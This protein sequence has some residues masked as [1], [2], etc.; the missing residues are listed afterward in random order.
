MRALV[1]DEGLS[2]RG[3]D[4]LSFKLEDPLEGLC[5]VGNLLRSSTERDH[6]FRLTLR[7][8]PGSCL[9]K[10][11]TSELTLVCVLVREK[12]RTDLAG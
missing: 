5:V 3:G 10:R 4:V 11:W 12:S 7:K 2:S 9:S 1:G 6:P 8:S